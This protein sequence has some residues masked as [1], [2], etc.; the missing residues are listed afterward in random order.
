MTLYVIRVVNFLKT[1]K[2]LIFL[3]FY[4]FFLK[5]FKKN[6]KIIFFYFPV[7][8]YQDNLIEL[9][10]EVDQDR[11]FKVFLGFNLGSSNKG[12]LLSSL[13]IDFLSS[14]GLFS[15]P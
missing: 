5:I 2:S 7:K 1:I 13:T 15:R 4:F 8:S 6:L 14:Y 3:N 12:S 11:N 9:I 10:K